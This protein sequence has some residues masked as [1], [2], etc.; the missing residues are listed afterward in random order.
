[1]VKHLVWLAIWIATYKDDNTM[2]N[3]IKT[4]FLFK[5]QVSILAVPGTVITDFQSL[6]IYWKI[7]I[8]TKKK[9]KKSMWLSLYLWL[10][11]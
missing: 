8:Y 11:N 4:S 10:F 3:G 5:I 2:S 9:Q 7:Q 1:M 6:S